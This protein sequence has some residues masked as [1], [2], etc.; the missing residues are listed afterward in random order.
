MT[1]RAV[2]STIIFVL[3]SLNHSTAT[4]DYV[5]VG[6]FTSSSCTNYLLFKSCQVVTVD[7]VRN[8]GKLYEIRKRWADVDRFNKGKGTCYVKISSAGSLALTDILISTLNS[9]VFYT[10]KNGQLEE[11]NIEHLNFKCV[12]R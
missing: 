12:K 6:P 9:Q 10:R 5:A 2:L 11:I 4:A 7:A 1:V 3:L 8:D